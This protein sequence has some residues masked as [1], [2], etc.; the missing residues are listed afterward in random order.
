MSY[1]Q[2]LGHPGGLWASLVALPA[3]PGASGGQVPPS[4]VGPVSGQGS[5]ESGPAGRVLILLVRPACTATES[6]ALS[7]PSTLRGPSP[8]LLACFPLVTRSFSA[9]H[10]LL[11][12]GRCSVPR[13]V[14]ETQH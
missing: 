8:R 5:A 4:S 1:R 14:S 9:S 11:F 2:S 6:P 3:V 13:V 7:P 10:P 12:E